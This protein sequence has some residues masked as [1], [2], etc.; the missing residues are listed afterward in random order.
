VPGGCR[1]LGARPGSRPRLAWLR[2]CG[3]YEGV[4]LVLV[5]VLVGAGAVIWWRV[6]HEKWGLV[7]R[8]VFWVALV[9]VLWVLVNFYSVPHP[10]V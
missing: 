6:S 7:R 8:V 2:D 3:D 10:E 1:F 9:A 5:L 4:S